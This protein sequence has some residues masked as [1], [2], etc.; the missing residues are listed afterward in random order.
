MEII[1][2]IIELFNYIGCNYSIDE[3]TLKKKMKNCQRMKIKQLLFN[4]YKVILNRFRI[5]KSVITIRLYVQ[6]SS[7]T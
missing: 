6:D 2:G 4:S 3:Q 1:I 5:G 7:I